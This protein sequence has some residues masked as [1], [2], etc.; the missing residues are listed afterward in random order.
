[1][2]RAS[3]AQHGNVKLPLFRLPRS[4]LAPVENLTPK[5]GHSNFIKDRSMPFTF[6]R[7][8]VQALI[9]SALVHL[10]LLISIAVIVPEK[11]S[12]TA[13]ALKVVMNAETRRPVAAPVAAPVRPVTP[14]V[15]RA[16]AA[17]GRPSAQAP[18]KSEE[19]PVLALAPTPASPSEAY[20]QAVPPASAAMGAEAGATASTTTPSSETS[21]G[22]VAKTIAG[23]VVNGVEAINKNDVAELRASLGSAAKRFKRYPRLARERAW[24]GTVEVVLVYGKNLQS[25]EIRV[26]RSSGRTML[27]EQAVDMLSRAVQTTALPAGLRGRDFQVTLPVVF[28][29]ED[30]Q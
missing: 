20:A 1:M 23:S 28:S 15:E 14:T 10:M 22:S 9:V 27:D 24:E 13:A 29:L 8:L 25:P 3:D 11:P 21:A 2:A 4:K 7:P 30:D 26:G 16:K 17:A 6:R 18:R 12:V 5:S 19:Q